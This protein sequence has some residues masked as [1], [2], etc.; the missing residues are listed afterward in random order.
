[1][2]DLPDFHDA[3][4]DA[5]VSHAGRSTLPFQRANRDEQHATAFWFN[6]LVDKSGEGEVIRQYLVTASGP[7]RVELAEFTLRPDLCTPAMSAEKLMMTDFAEGWTHLGDLGV[8]VM[9]TSGLHAHG[10]RKGWS[11]T[12]DEI[13]DG[14]AATEEDIATLGEVPIA[15]YVLGH[16]TEDGDREQAVVVGQ[17][18]RTSDGTLQWVGDLPQGCVGAPVFIGARLGGNSFKLVCVGVALPADGR[19]GIAP[20]DRIRAALNSLPSNTPP[21]F[22]GTVTRPQSIEPKRRWWQRRG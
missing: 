4:I 2:S 22:D 5:I 11:W 16:I 15:A 10:A 14:I 18:V 7:A 17:V 6:E 8:A 19:H 9:P 1:M 21:A 13:T 20:F 12:T 3:A